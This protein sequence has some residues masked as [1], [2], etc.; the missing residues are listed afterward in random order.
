MPDFFPNLIF[1]S[2]QFF[3]FEM[4]W[5]LCLSWNSIGVFGT[6]FWF[7][8]ES[9]T[10]YLGSLQGKTWTLEKIDFLVF[11]FNRQTFL[12]Q[13]RKRFCQKTSIFFCFGGGGCDLGFSIEMLWKNCLFSWRKFTKTILAFHMVSISSSD[14]MLIFCWNKSQT[15]PIQNVFVNSHT[16]LLNERTGFGEGSDECF[17][18]LGQSWTLITTS[19]SGRSS[20]ISR[21]KCSTP[22]HLQNNNWNYLCILIPKLHIN[23]IN[24]NFAGSI[25]ALAMRRCVHGKD[26]LRLFSI[27]AKLSTRC[28][29]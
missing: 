19:M 23:T 20:I 24:P 12:H 14:L 17:I 16:S 13:K 2:A 7:I 28:G 18:D 10:A 3:W 15:N 9:H 26:T 4:S 11:T 27:G 8:L 5:I 1:F 6:Q 29:G 22:E 21:M 25:P